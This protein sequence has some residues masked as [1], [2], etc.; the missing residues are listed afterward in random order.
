MGPF[1]Y[2]LIRMQV[3]QE[4]LLRQ[5]YT[6]P[7]EIW[8]SEDLEYIEAVLTSDALQPMDM[9]ALIREKSMGPYTNLP[10]STL[11][12]DKYSGKLPSNIYIDAK[13]DE[14]FQIILTTLSLCK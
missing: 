3:R 5:S 6:A 13:T 4:G 8:S 12:A 1:I 7:L 14:M 11:L 10:L 9:P 2:E